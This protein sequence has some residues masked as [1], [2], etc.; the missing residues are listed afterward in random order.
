M[1]ERKVAYQVDGRPF[2]GVIVYDDSVTGKRPAVFMHPDWKG[3]SPDTIAQARTVAGTDYVVLM[4]DM[5]GAGYGDK[6]KTR[7]QLA[8][9]M[10]AVHTDLPFTL[11]CGGKACDTLLAEADRLG[12]IDTAK[13]VAIG[14]CA[15]GGFALEQARA[16]A[17]FK[18]VV[19]F[20]VT[21]P[22]PVVPGTPCRI[23]G[24]VLAIHGSADPVT[25]KPMMDALEDELTKA[26]VD[27]QVMMFGGAVHSFC[28]PTA[29]AMPSIYDAKLCR[30]SYLL[31]RDFFAETL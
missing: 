2:E 22:N 6:P 18:A 10:R 7:E 19:V 9:G 28:D 24:R 13:T 20:H 3:V 21:N 4:A 5:F 29:N 23:K 30:K 16:G 1:A 11:A 8:A 25:P 26:K 12:L 15:G 17:D 27:W 31:M 14:Y